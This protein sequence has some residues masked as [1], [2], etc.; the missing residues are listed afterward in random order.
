MVTTAKGP[1]E[2]KKAVFKAFR[3]EQVM[4]AFGKQGI[5]R[6]RLDLVAVGEPKPAS[7]IL[8]KNSGLVGPNGK[9]IH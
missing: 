8:T 4:K 5:S 7:K 6:V 3:D 9:P 1:D 2:G